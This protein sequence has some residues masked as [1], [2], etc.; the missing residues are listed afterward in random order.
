MNNIKTTVIIPA[1]N[2]E[3]GLS[4]VLGKIV[5]IVD[6][7]YEIIV[8]D[9]GSTDMTSDI[10]SRFPCRLIK[11][12]VNKG[13][14]AALL[15]GIINARGENI[16]W[17]DAD[18]TYPV[19]LIPQMAEYLL[20]Y[21]MVVCS[22]KYGRHR[23]PKFNRIGNWLFRTMIC[24]IYG[25]QAFDPCT[26]LYGTRKHHLLSMKL[27]AKRFAIEPEISIKG[28]R[29][30]LKTLDI[31]IE[32]RNRIGTSNLN[33]IAVGFEDLFMILSLLFWKSPRNMRVD[34]AA[35]IAL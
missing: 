24:G 31:P 19:E 10:A 21:D 8:V 3:A 13:K 17:I 16:I 9:D 28:G 14:G 29:M 18:D 23:I 15:T 12:K 6:D 25:F 20:T 4:I 22:R 35:S 27:S 5:N 11:H 33:G 34:E 1:K 7:T 2:E 32:Y 26:G 30:K